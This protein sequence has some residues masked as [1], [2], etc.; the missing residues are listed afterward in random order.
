MA[1]NEYEQLKITRTFAA[2]RDVVWSAWTQPDKF[3]Q[4][5]MPAPFSIPVCELDVRPEGE[6]RFDSKS[7][8]GSVMHTVGVYKIVEEPERLVFTNGP[9]DTDGNKIF[10]VQ[11]TLVLTEIGGKTQL[12]LTSEVLSAGSSAAPYLAGMEQGLNQALGQLANL[13]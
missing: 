11:H 9:L 6:I 7:P 8:D 2:A 1:E 4:W 12:D 13:L 5:Y 3:M 10:E